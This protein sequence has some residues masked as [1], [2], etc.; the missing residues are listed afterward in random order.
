MDILSLSFL[1]PRPPLPSFYILWLKMK[2]NLWKM[3]GCMYLACVAVLVFRCIQAELDS[4]TST[5]LLNK[6]LTNVILDLSVLS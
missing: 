1:Q 4:M 5:Y 3:T 6:E 2:C